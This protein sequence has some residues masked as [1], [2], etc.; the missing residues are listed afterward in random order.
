MKSAHTLFA[1]LHG[2]NSIAIMI[3]IEILSQINQTLIFV[4][5]SNPD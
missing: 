1:L 5:Q 2:K 3:P 4:F